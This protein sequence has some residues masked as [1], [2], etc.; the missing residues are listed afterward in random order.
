[1]NTREQKQIEGSKG[2]KVIRVNIDPGICG[3]GCIIRA[4]KQEKRSLSIDIESDCE[5]IQKL[6]D[7]LPDI[8][9]KELFLPLSQN[10]IFQIA[11]RSRCHTACPIPSSIVKIAEVALGLALPKNATLRFDG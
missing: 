6:A 11:E 5:Q 3:F 1:M 7:T 9:I 4:M 8:S 10:P 2:G